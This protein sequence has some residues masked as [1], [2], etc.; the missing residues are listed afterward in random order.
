MRSEVSPFWLV[1]TWTICSPVRILGNRWLNGFSCFIP[2]HGGVLPTMHILLF[3]QE[4]QLDLTVYLSAFCAVQSSLILSLAYFSLP[5]LRDS[6][7]C[8]STQWDLWIVFE[9]LLLVLQPGS[10]FR[11]VTWSDQKIRDCSPVLSVVQYLKAL[12]HIY[13]F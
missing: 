11:T 2:H 3:S 5:L 4:N 7:L 12:F 1:G 10:C 6:D 8:P 13:F 9:F